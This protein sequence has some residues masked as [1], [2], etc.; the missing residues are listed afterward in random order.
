MPPG[1]ARRFRPWLPIWALAASCV[2]GL[3]LACAIERLAS[4]R[5]SPARRLWAALAWACGW[6]G[7]TGV[8]W[9]RAFYTATGALLGIHPWPRAGVPALAAGWIFWALLLSAALP[10][11]RRWSTAQDIP[12]APG[13]PAPPPPLRAAA[14]SWRAPAPPRRSPA[15]QARDGTIIGIA[16]GRRAVALLDAEL[17]AHTLVLGATGAGKT[18]ALL[19]LLAPAIARGDPVVCIDGKGSAELLRLVRAACARADRDLRAFTF[20][21]GDHYNPLRHG[22]PT[23]RRDLLSAAQQWNNAYFQAV[24]ENYLGVAAEALE[25]AGEPTTLRRLAALIQPDLRA[26]EGMIRRVGDREVFERLM[27]R[28]DQTDQSARSGIIGLAHRLGRLSDSRIG[29]WL[30]PA[31]P[32]AREL[33]LLETATTPGGPVAHFSLDTLGYPA[34]AAPL[35]AMVLQ[36]LQFVASELMARGSTAAVHVFIDEFA[37]FD[38]QQLLGLLGRAREA[39]IRCVLATQDLADL[40]R[41]GGRTAVDQVLA[42]TGVKLTLRC[43]VRTTAERIADTVGTRPQWRTTHRTE[44][45]RTTAEG[46]ARIEET[47]LLQ[48]GVLMQLGP[49]EA[50]V[51]KKH[52]RLSLDH[53]RLFKAEA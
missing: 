1:F 18:N 2:V 6:T 28:V 27:V 10:P 46:S 9:L 43:D 26:L 19:L 51:I 50:V 11:F 3:L 8:W 29:P 34:T 48:P 17:R 33:D 47:P 40:E 24:A 22:D 5:A 53:V 4:A 37:P 15:A 39:G 13:R 14:D 44:G 41:T 35:A 23:H 12:A 52:P 36:D 25:A 38:V 45:A 30:E 21:G 7:L 49:G 32:G 20:A 16:A 31:G 42:N